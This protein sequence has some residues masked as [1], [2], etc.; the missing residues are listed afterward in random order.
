MGEKTQINVHKRK[1]KLHFWYGL[2]KIY[3][4]EHYTVSVKCMNKHF[5]FYIPTVCPCSLGQFYVE[6]LSKELSRLLGHTVAS[7]GWP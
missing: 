1:V 7:K 6:T 4:N 5:K 2:K 3:M